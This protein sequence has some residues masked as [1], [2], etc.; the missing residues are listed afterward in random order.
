MVTFFFGAH[1][2]NFGKQVMKGFN[3]E[4]F[5]FIAAKLARIGM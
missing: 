2:V 5:A 1:E 3:Y 4:L